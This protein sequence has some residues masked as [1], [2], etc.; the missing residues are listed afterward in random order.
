MIK[1]HYSVEFKDEACRLV[2]GQGYSPS[3]AASKLGVDLPHRNRARFG[4][5]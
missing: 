5:V 2:T 4:S 1:K 3:A